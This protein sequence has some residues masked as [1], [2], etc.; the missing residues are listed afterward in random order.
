MMSNMSLL[1]K[2]YLILATEGLLFSSSSTR[3]RSAGAQY[4]NDFMVVSSLH[5]GMVSSRLHLDLVDI[6]CPFV[7]TSSC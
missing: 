1:H 4:L 5:L 6:T 7:T 2:L 3:D